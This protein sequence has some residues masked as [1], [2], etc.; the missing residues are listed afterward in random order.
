MEGFIRS[1]RSG[2]DSHF[3]GRLGGHHLVDWWGVRGAL[4]LLVVPR[5]RPAEHAG[6]EIHGRCDI[7][8][9]PP[10]PLHPNTPFDDLEPTA[11][12]TAVE[13]A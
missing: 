8:A 12:L 5:P 10:M 6:G 11:V 4:A 2:G 13:V 1:P 7:S 3:P 9:E